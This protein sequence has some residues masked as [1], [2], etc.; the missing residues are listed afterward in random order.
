M[1]RALLS[2]LQSHRGYPSVTVL[3]NTSPGA[4][5]Q[6]V[7]LATVQALIADADERL[8]RE[9]SDDVRR[10]LVDTLNELVG[11]QTPHSASHALGLFASPT[12]TTAVRLGQHVTERVIIDETFA[13]RDLVADLNRTAQY[14]VLSVSDKAARLFLGDRHRLVEERS[15]NWPLVRE[16]EMNT[17]AWNARL[18]AAVREEHQRLAVPT[19]F[20]GVERSVRKAMSGIDVSTIGVIP[21]NHD[22][23]GWAPLHNLAW[24]LVTD[25]LRS[26][27]TRALQLLEQARSQKRY[28]GGIEE[29]WVL[30]NAGRIEHLIVEEGYAVAA[31]LEGD[32]VIPASDATAPGVIDDLVDEA[33]EVVIAKGGSVVLMANGDLFNSDRIAATLRY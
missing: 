30:A 25:W 3:F 19:V 14:R 7:Q 31:T 20:A 17:T 21:G 10:Q 1:Q 6:P 13:T 22:K 26:D 4:T 28:A 8:K 5:I 15:D 2:E 23:T 33:I 29:V 18:S 27:R 32:R 12:I 11:Q 9:V 16:P 24:P